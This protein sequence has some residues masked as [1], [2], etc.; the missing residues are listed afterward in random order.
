MSATGSC[1]EPAR[2]GL[3][4]SHATPLAADDLEWSDFNLWWAEHERVTTLLSI[5]PETEEETRNL[6]VDQGFALEQLIVNTPSSSMDAVRAK[7][8]ILL[9]LMVMERHE[10]AAAMRDIHDFVQR[11]IR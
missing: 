11:A 6:L 2:R 7:T 3:N 5:T 8:N 10:C 9:W 1:S 4:S